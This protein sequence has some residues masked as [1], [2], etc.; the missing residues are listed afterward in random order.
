MLLVEMYPASANVEIEPRNVERDIEFVGQGLVNNK[1]TLRTY[2]YGKE[3]TDAI[4]V[5]PAPGE[6]MVL[7]IFGMSLILPISHVL[8]VFR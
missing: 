8:I 1:F 5:L 7:H 6:Q 2:G 3:L 4:I